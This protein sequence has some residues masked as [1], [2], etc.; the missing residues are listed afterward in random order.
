MAQQQPKGKKQDRKADTQKQAPPAPEAPA[1]G[2][3]EISEEELN[4]L[5]GGVEASSENIRH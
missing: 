5:A 3:G 1:R 2:D 4:K